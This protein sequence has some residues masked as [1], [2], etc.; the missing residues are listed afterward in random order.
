MAGKKGM[1]WKKHK[2][3]RKEGNEYIYPDGMND[4]ASEVNAEYYA[5]VSEK[6]KDGFHVS[7]YSKKAKAMG[8]KDMPDKIERKAVNAKHYT[9]TGEYTDLNGN[10]VTQYSKNIRGMGYKKLPNHITVTTRK[11]VDKTINANKKKKASSMSK[12]IRAGIEY[13]KKVLST[14]DPY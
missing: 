6:D 3:L 8:Y 9:K 2:Y 4:N 11:K 12:C 1:K 13:L 14:P 10:T 7:T 5:L